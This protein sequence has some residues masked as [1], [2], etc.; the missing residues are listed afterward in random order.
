MYLHLN[1]CRV[2]FENFDYKVWFNCC[3]NCFDSPT[4]GTYFLLFSSPFCYIKF[5]AILNLYRN[6]KQ[7]DNF[8]NEIFRL[9]RAAHKRS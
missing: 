5:V 6:V 7:L 3:D 9:L 4:T 8:V 2:V 1:F